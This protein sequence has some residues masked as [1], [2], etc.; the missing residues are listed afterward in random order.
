MY[1]TH[2][3]RF[4]KFVGHASAA[5]KD[6][7]LVKNCAKLNISPILH[8]SSPER[9]LF[10]NNKPSKFFQKRLLY[11]I[12]VCFV[13]LFPVSGLSSEDTAGLWKELRAGH[14]FVL[15]RHASAP[16]MGDPDY[17]DVE[18]CSTQRNLSDAG[19]KQAESIGNLF[20]ANG[21]KKAHVFSSQW[22]RC[23]ETA[24]LL[25]LG[26]VEVLPHLNSFFQ[27][28]ELRDS[29]TENLSKWIDTQNIEDII[30]LVT[31]Q[32]NITSLTDVYPSSGEL[33]FVD[34]S[35]S[36][37]LSVLGSIKTD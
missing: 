7:S 5:A 13:I 20:R 23:L 12:L 37:K 24:S 31:H 32:V 22:C 36:G 33:V 6:H 18:D 3:K 21:I 4:T 27:Q 2:P 26:A 29:Q 15:L 10:S 14:S 35:Q 1:T 16:G 25:K 34:R 8:I 28:Y 17:F 11:C 19:R 9:S 30:V